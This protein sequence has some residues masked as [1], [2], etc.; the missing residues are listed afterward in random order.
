[1]AR[2]ITQL[3]IVDRQKCTGCKTCVQICPVTAIKLQEEE[4]K[5][6]AV[7]DEQY[8]QACTL[9]VTRCPEIAITMNS[10][11][12]PLK[13]GMEVSQAS[14]EEVATIC[15]KAHMYPDQIVCYCHR[16][17]AKE[18]AG[19]ILSGAKTPEEVSRMT[20]ARTGCGVLCI[21]GVVRLL[22]AA[23]LKIERAPGYQWYG[24]TV[25]IWDL[26]DEVVQKYDK[27]YYLLRD[28]KDLDEIF[29]G[30]GHQ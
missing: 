8:C 21:T 7:I 23:G 11:N 3:A 28:R 26:P 12:S 19:A 13:I 20:G 24:T 25:S 1:M 17:Q 2:I 22:R 4:G 29:P 27:G 30:G 5:P 6:K 16:I 9:C 15:H 10:R 18:I 14:S